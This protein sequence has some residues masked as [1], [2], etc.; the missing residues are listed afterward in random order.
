MKKPTVTRRPKALHPQHR[1]IPMGNG[2]RRYSLEQLVS[3]IKRANRHGET[4]WGPPEG[5]E[6]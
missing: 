2:H 6:V 1:S 4:D 5:K 3:G